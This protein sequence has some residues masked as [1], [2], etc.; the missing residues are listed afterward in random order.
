MKSLVLTEVLQSHTVK[1]DDF[2]WPLQTE[3]TRTGE[4]WEDKSFV[5]DLSYSLALFSCHYG[6]QERQHTRDKKKARKPNLE[7]KELQEDLGEQCLV[8]LLWVFGGQD[9]WD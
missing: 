6:L 8:L 1:P 9:V 2:T 4:K 3:V 7:P 5:L